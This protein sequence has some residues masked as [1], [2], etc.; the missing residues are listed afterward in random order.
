MKDFQA[1][2][3][4]YLR[5]FATDIRLL[6]QLTVKGADWDWGRDAQQT[7]NKMKTRLTTAPVLG[8]LEPEQPYV[9][10]ERVIAYFNKTLTSP[11]K[12]Y[13]VTRKKL[14]AVIEA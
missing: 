14:L 7:F 10:E 5:Y 11:E 6:N 4:T 12:N 2:L 3:G 8:Y 1:F 13:Y 9:L